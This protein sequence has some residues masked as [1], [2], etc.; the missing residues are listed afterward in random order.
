MTTLLLF[1][2]ISLVLISLL[3]L[4]VTS[5]SVVAVQ[6]N[7]IKAMQNAQNGML[8]AE[9]ELR[10]RIKE[11]NSRIA[12]ITPSAIKG[13][14]NAIYASISNQY[15]QSEYEI[16]FEE[17]T[18]IA[19]QP[20]NGLFSEKV[21]LKAIGKDGG[22]SKTY[23]KTLVLSTV[24][25]LFNYELVTPG[26]LKLYGAPYLQGDLY[27]GGDLYTYNQASFIEG[28]THWVNT[29]YPA[30]NGN[31][32]LGKKLYKG[33]DKS[34]RNRLEITPENLNRYFSIAPGMKAANLTLPSPTLVADAFSDPKISGVPSTS[35]TIDEP[36]FSSNQTYPQSTRIAGKPSNRVTIKKNVTV[37]VH[38]NFVIDGSLQMEEGSSLIVDGNLYIGGTAILR[39][40]VE[41]SEE[42]RVYING[43]HGS[44]FDDLFDLIKGII[45]QDLG[46]IL[47][48][49]FG[50]KHFTA[51]LDRLTFRGSMYVNGNMA[52]NKHLNA[53]SAIYAREDIDINDLN[54]EG[55]GTL[56]LLSGGNIEMYNNNLY[57]D[58]PKEIDAYLFS[59]GELT[60]YGVGSNVKINGGVYGNPVTLSATKGKT[61]DNDSFNES[62]DGRLQSAAH[63]GSDYFDPRQLTLP[64][65]ASRLSIIYKKEMILNP[66]SGIPTVKE[67]NISEIDGRFE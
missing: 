54:N 48:N 5:H 4:T 8:M 17:R 39:G 9:S 28:Y 27:V 44:F 2:V 43:G 62:V 26:D 41:V 57:Q 32:T 63:V 13:E 11:L 40:N 61:A 46:D 34:N 10:K 35:A 3:E 60:I 55:G 66:P 42:K 22:S 37:E 25:D 50:G 45:G 52:V 64:P 49:L 7:A 33:T 51:V 6:E 56:I 24:A 31:L 23:A 20:E 29:A 53:N 59:A 65:E 38:G 12:G 30:I 1:L 16:R 18:A 58:Q 47:K 14:L 19:D 67:I 15:S 36:V 21:T